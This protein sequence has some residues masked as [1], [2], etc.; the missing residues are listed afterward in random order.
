MESFFKNFIV[1]IIIAGVIT[2]IL[3]YF[4]GKKMDQK[5][6]AIAAALITLVVTGP[7]VVIFL[8]F[9]VAV[10]EYGVALFLWWLA[11]LLWIDSKRRKD[12]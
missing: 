5:S 12:S 10:T 2:R 9:D 11:D 6:A 8:G 7:I 1:L 3:K 4:L